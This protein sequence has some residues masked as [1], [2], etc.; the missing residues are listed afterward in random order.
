MIRFNSIQ[1][2]CYY[3]G[4]RCSWWLLVMLSERPSKCKAVIEA[5]WGYFEEHIVPEP[6]VYFTF[7]FRSDH[8]SHLIKFPSSN[9]VTAGTTPRSCRTY[10]QRTLLVV[11]R[12][13]ERQNLHVKKTLIG[14]NPKLSPEAPAPVSLST[15]VKP[16]SQHHPRGHI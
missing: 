9:R 6:S 3:T 7:S 14:L 4:T 16:T 8:P 5:K 2:Y 11:T 13:A 1:L 10:K 12:M 15:W